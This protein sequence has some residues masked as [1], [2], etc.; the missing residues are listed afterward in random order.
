MKMRIEKT[1]SGHAMCYKIYDGSEF[2][3]IVESKRTA[4][5]FVS[6]WIKHKEY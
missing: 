4:E 5:L 2:I 6:E 3:T 1:V